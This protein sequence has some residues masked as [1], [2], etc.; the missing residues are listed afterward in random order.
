MP[1]K[2]NERKTID[3]DAQ[4]VTPV[5]T[6]SGK[7]IPGLFHVSMPETD[8][9][10][11]QRIFMENQTIDKHLNKARV[12]KE[13]IRLANKY[14]ES[15]EVLYSNF[16][17][18]FRGRLYS[19]AF[20]LGLQQRDSVRSLLCAADPKPL[21]ERGVYWL[22]V[23]VATH[24][25]NGIEKESFVARSEWTKGMYASGEL[26]KI[27]WC[28]TH[29]KTADKTTQDWKDYGYYWRM[30]DDPGR[31][32]AAAHDYCAAM[33][34]GDP[35][36]YESAVFIEFD[37]TA[38]GIQIM[39]A[40]TADE[41]AQYVN[42]I[43][44]PD[45]KRQDIYKIVAD[46]TNEMLREIVNKPKALLEVTDEVTGE[47]LI[48]EDGTTIIDEDEDARKKAQF[49]LDWGLTRTIMKRPV[50]TFGYSA[51]TMTFYDQIYEET[52]S[53][54]RAKFEDFTKY[55]Y[56]LARMLYE[57]VLPNLLPGIMEFM[58]RL[59]TVAYALSELGLPI[60]F[61]SIHGL[62]FYQM[63][64]KEEERT[65]DITCSLGRIQLVAYTKTNEIDAGAQAKAI[66]PNIVHHG[67][68]LLMQKTLC[69]LFD[70][71]V[72]AL[73]P[74][75]DCFGVLA[76]DAE[77]LYCTVRR[78]FAALFNPT[79]MAELWDKITAPLREHAEE[80]LKP[81]KE[82]I[83]DLQRQVTEIKTKKEGDAKERAK[84][85]KKLRKRV[86][87]IEA[88]IKLVTDAA[89]LRPPVGNADVS[90]VI[91]SEFLFS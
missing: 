30:A 46:K 83:A 39:A 82:Q 23:G 24:F 63:E 35:E 89:V 53:D 20:A 85:V 7:E 13:S 61:T 34:S 73:I 71:G 22:S 29:A 42:V 25:G 43:P 88:S 84:A 68:G 79:T 17:Y 14:R 32:L 75:H 41:S 28:A 9:R 57:D 59:K 67:D 15:G 1:M 4:N 55:V 38:S 64:M 50:M 16:F 51:V 10:E 66:V 70:A 18:D 27:V 77:L 47:V 21:G 11:T 65:I 3:L 58:N 54:P 2:K 74:V 56:F 48:A 5:T 62:P 86:E 44:S 36:K 12:V 37:A 8:A 26:Q 6:K 33:E 40:W 81:L 52:Y 91:H 87:R 76:A 69:D 45:G 80:G 31:F 60:E 49:W 72:T 90:Q 78:N 19:S